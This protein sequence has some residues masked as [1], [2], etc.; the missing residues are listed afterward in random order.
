MTTANYATEKYDQVKEHHYTCFKTVDEECDSVNYVYMARDNNNYYAVLKNGMDGIEDILHIDFEGGSA[1]G[2]V[3]TLQAKINTWYN[4]NMTGYT[5]YLEDTIYCN[6]R[7]IYNPWNLTSSIANDD[8]SKLNFGAKGR[9]AFTGEVTIECKYK[10]DSFTVSS[11]IGN[12]ALV[13]PVGTVSY[14]EA[15]FAGVAWWKSS[16]DSFLNNGKV[17]WTMS[18]GFISTTGVYNGI[19]SSQLDHVAVNWVGS[20]TTINSINYYQGGG[21]R[22]VISLKPNTVIKNGFGT[23]DKPFKIE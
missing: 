10:A 15:A 6:D 14:D 17:W 12:G 16:A 13:N 7:S 2:T 5:D 3:S 1:N 19:I 9:V 8:N 11:E 20:K 21:V 22:P 18:P 23:V 4:G